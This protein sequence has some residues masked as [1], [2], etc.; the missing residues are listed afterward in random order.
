MST[1]HADAER[2]DRLLVFTQGRARRAARALHPGA[3]RRGAAAAHAERRAEILQANDELAAQALRTLG[4]ALP[5]AAAPTALADGRR[6]TSASSEISCS[7]A[8]SA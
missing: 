3:R 6:W 8:W 7:R 4:V 1:V 2:Q 5:R